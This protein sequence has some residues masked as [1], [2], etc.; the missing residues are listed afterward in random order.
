MGVD[1]PAGEHQAP[2]VGDPVE[3][4]PAECDRGVALGELHRPE[5]FEGLE[6]LLGAV[7]L[8]LVPE[9]VHP[10]Q[11]SNPGALQR[12]RMTGQVLQDHRDREEPGNGEDDRERAGLRAGQEGAAEP[13][14]RE[15]DAGEQARHDD[16][17]RRD[18]RCRTPLAGF[19]IGERGGEDLAARHRLAQRVGREDDRQ[20][21]PLRDPQARRAQQ[22]ALD[23]GETVHRQHRGDETRRD[24]V[25]LDLADTQPGAP[26]F[27]PDENDFDGEDDQDDGE[28]DPSDPPEPR[29]GHRGCRAPRRANILRRHTCHP[30]VGGPVSVTTPV[31]DL[32]N[33]GCVRPPVTEAQH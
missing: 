21:L 2:D 4:A 32:R 19:P 3:Q 11:D 25:P 1:R 8:R 29:T 16:L 5:L 18:D 30:R 9:L 23:L 28:Q 20:G 27:G 26:Q 24:P 10:T 6:Q 33:R 15:T 14:H 31:G 7:V 13:E 17:P 22:C 12:F